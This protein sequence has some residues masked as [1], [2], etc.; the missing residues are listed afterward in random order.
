MTPPAR[1]ARQSS[2]HHNGEYQ[3]RAS[4]VNNVPG[5][6]VLRMSVRLLKPPNPHIATTT[7]TTTSRI[8]PYSSGTRMGFRPVALAPAPIGRRPPRGMVSVGV[9]SRSELIGLGR[10]RLHRLSVSVLGG[11]LMR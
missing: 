5:D 1:H 10:C 6:V 7:S 2:R 3:L 9:K 11:E 8:E 4:T